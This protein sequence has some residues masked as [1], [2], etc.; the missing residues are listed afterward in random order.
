MRP[1]A[2]FGAALV[3][4]LSE[5]A[6]AAAGELRGEVNLAGYVP[7]SCDVRYTSKTVAPA[8]AVRIDLG[9]ITEQ[10]NDRNGFQVWAEYVPGISAA[11]LEV[12]GVVRT[13]S[14]TGS[15]LIDSSAGAGKQM[16]HL[17]LLVS[18]TSRRPP[19][20]AIRITPR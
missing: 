14:P 10:C 12:D 7:L 19:A 4:V 3:F 1:V 15:I 6:P 5:T 9:T 11:A 16:H 13:P 20:I 8:T 2:N 17:V 18:D